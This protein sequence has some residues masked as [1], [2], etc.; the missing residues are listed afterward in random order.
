MLRSSP[1]VACADTCPGSVCRFQQWYIED[2]PSKTYKGKSVLGGSLRG[3]LWG[4]LE[5]VSGGNSA[6]FG[7]PCC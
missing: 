7:L 5:D 6:L 1:C 2:L 4:S 3:A